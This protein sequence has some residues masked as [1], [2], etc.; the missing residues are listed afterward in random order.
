MLAIA[1]PSPQGGGRN[2]QR[3]IV[4]R[5]SHDRRANPEAN[6]HLEVASVFEHGAVVQCRSQVKSSWMESGVLIPIRPGRCES[7]NSL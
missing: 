7:A 1:S 2:K 4:T 5:E 6:Q 3:F